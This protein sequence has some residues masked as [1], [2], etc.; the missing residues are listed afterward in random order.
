[1][2]RSLVG[3]LCRVSLEY[4]FW[5]R[6]DA[7]HFGQ[8]IPRMVGASYKGKVSE[9]ALIVGAELYP[10]TLVKAYKVLHNEKIRWVSPYAITPMESV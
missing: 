9:P 5:D 4:G 3:S 2:T 7:V 8:G 10:N 1:M 6:T